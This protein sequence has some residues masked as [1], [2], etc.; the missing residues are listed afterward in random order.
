MLLSITNG[1]DK[2]DINKKY[3]K[4]ITDHPKLTGKL[5]S[6]DWTTISHFSELGL[7]EECSE[8]SQERNKKVYL[9]SMFSYVEEGIAVI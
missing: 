9:D 3:N 2:L 5:H 1:L 7:I 6:K 8:T 4:D